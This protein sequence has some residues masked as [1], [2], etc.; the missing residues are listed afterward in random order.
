MGRKRDEGDIGRGGRQRKRAKS[1]QVTGPEVTACSLLR[2]L[3]VF[4][5]FPV[6]PGSPQ[7]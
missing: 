3:P 6:A 4:L 2:S 7:P 1:S 5:P